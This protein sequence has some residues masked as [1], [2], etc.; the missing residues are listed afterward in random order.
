MQEN[1]GWKRTGCLKGKV[2]GYR[3][4]HLKVTG[5]NQIQFGRMKA[6]AIRW[7]LHCLYKTSWWSQAKPSKI[8][9]L[10]QKNN[11]AFRTDWNRGTK[12]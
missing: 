11:H 12:V 1:Q 9:V 6:V 7:L 2:T 3:A 4:L 5:S 8:G 10:H